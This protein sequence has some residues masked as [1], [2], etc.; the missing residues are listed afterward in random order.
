VE[1]CLRFRERLVLSAI[2]SS[3]S[4]RIVLVNTVTRREG[5]STDGGS[6][7]GLN[8]K[9]TT[10]SLIRL[11]DGLCVKEVLIMAKSK[12]IPDKHHDC[13][14]PNCGDVK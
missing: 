14:F 12:E 1:G 9:I 10:F 8:L 7:S 13:H 4:F 11:E 5:K 2:N 6:L 3:F